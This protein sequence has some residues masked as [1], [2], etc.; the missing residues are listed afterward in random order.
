MKNFLSEIFMFWKCFQRDASVS[1]AEFKGS[2]IIIIVISKNVKDCSFVRLIEA[3]CLINYY[4]RIHK[5]KN[6]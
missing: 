2:K 1:K 5:N 6:I 4:N 3:L